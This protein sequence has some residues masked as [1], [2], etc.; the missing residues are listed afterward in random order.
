MQD[1]Y[2]LGPYARSFSL[3]NVKLSNIGRQLAS[4]GILLLLVVFAFCLQFSFI[5]IVAKA[6][7]VHFSMPLGRRSPVVLGWDMAGQETIPAQSPKL[8]AAALPYYRGQRQLAVAM[9]NSN[10]CHVLI[11]CCL[12][13]KFELKR[14]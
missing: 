7:F 6:F 4:P 5:N 3:G 11:P 2:I 14:Q 12:K 1:S 13:L 9:A 8:Q 10:A